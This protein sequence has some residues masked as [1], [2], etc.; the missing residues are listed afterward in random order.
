MGKPFRKVIDPLLARVGYK[1]DRLQPRTYPVEFDAPDRDIVSYVTKNELSMTSPERLFATLLACRYACERGIAGDFVE[2]GVWRGGNAMVAAD[3]FRRL[4]PARKTYLFD[5]FAGMTEPTEA[6][7]SRGGSRAADEYRRMSRDGHSEWCYASLEDVRGGFEARGLMAGAVFVKGD[8][9]QT[10]LDAPSL[11]ERISVL[12]LDTDWY[13][14]TKLE[15]EVLYP[16]LR[17]GG[18]L[19]VDDYGYWGGARKAI[20]EYFSAHPKPFFQYVDHT[21]RMGI[22]TP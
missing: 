10:L 14:S 16:K 2:C 20:D 13:E 15:L 22:K 18:V 6:D 19:I 3:V 4:A 17:P 9:A 7:V 5:T 11:P 12:R 21:A 8:V 1:L